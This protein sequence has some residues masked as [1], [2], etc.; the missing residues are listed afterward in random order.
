MQLHLHSDKTVKEVK[1]EFSDH[2][3]YL[4]LEF[5]LSKHDKGSE[6][7]YDSEVGNNHTLS[8]VNSQLK[9]ASFS[10]EP[11]MSVAAFEDAMQEH[12]GLS[13]QVFRKM[14]D[15]WI[16]TD[17]TDDLTLEQQNQMGKASAT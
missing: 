6:P 2:F 5:Y 13:V 14:G 11:T 3:P 7:D 16:E 17:E 12:Y 1:H 15:V 10:F 4:N 9:D 8:Q